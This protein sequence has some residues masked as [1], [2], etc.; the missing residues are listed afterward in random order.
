[1][2]RGLYDIALDARTEMQFYNLTKSVHR[3]FGYFT[4]QRFLVSL[5]RIGCE[6]VLVY[7]ITLVCVSMHFLVW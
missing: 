7:V 2:H 3:V 4:T 6:E 1:M 5:V